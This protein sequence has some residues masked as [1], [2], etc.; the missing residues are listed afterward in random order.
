MTT[1]KGLDVSFSDYDPSRLTTPGPNVTDEFMEI[2]F[3]YRYQLL[4][5]DDVQAKFCIVCPQMTSTPQG[6]QPPRA[7]KGVVA[8]GSKP[9]VQV[10]FD[11]KNPDHVTFIG[12]FGNQYEFTEDEEGRTVPVHKDSK[13]GTGFMGTFRDWC[14][15][16][17]ALYL[18]SKKGRTTPSSK[19]LEEAEAKIEKKFFWVYSNHRDGELKGQ[20]DPINGTPMRYFKLLN[21]KPGTPEENTAKFTLPDKTKVDSKILYGRQFVWTPILSGRRIYE[22]KTFAVQMEVGEAVI[23]DILEK[24]PRGVSVPMRT[25]RLVERISKDNPEQAAMI[26]AKYKLLLQEEKAAPE[27]KT[28]DLKI[29]DVVV[30]VQDQTSAE[31]Q[32]AKTPVPETRSKSASPDKTVQTETSRRRPTLPPRK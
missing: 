30:K 25:S 29:D 26:A 12:D 27:N 11:M 5:T 24:V 13:K 23:N 9:S 20:P 17:Y 1:Q 3:E 10:A 15:F 4:G 19:N 31:N 21:Y 32:E 28:G 8:E 6:I 7:Y 2:R 22:A 18:A 16:Q 14:I